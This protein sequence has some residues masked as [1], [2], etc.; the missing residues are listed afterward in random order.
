MQ[1][2]NINNKGAM[3]AI[4]HD[5]L[6]EVRQICDKFSKT[7]IANINSHNQII[8]SGP[9]QQIED[10]IQLFKENKINFA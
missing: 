5:N 8:I 6:N 9:I 3:L 1:K 10:S 2:A 7:V 4:I